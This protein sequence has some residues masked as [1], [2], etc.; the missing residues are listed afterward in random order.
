MKVDSNSSVE[1][2]LA[3][4]EFMA[5]KRRETGVGEISTA[6]GLPKSTT[7]RL[8]E[9]LKA[10]G[11]VEQV[12][13][14]EKYEIGV[15]AI[16]VGM[17]GLKNWIDIASDYVRQVSK[18]LGETCFIAVYDNGEIVYVYKVEGWQSVITNAQLGTRKPIHSTGLGKAIVSHFE[19]AEVDKILS[20]KGMPRYT[21]NTITDRQ[22]F[23]QELSNIRERGYALDQEEAESGLSCIAVPIFTYTGQVIAATSI[24]GPTQRIN[25]RRETIIPRLKDTAENISKRLGYV[26]SMRSNQ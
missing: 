10:R 26:P 1:R 21:E 17:S 8:L 19:L 20:V 23:L 14:T 18:E 2:V 6:L 9:T 13:M 4:L 25:E 12:Q 16:E 24:A 22:Q 11:F 5:E 15:K 7:H 3:I